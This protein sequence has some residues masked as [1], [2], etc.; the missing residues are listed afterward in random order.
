MTIRQAEQ[1]QTRA[2]LLIKQAQMARVIELHQVQGLST[3]CV[4]DRLKISEREVCDLLE[5][6]TRGR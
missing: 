5:E 1:D 3:F 4:A 2:A 6:V